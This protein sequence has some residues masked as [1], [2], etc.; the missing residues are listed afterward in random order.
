MRSQM[1]VS[2][3]PTLPLSGRQEAIAV[4]ADSKAACPLQGLVRRCRISTGSDCGPTP[5]KQGSSHLR[6]TS[7]TGAQL[8]SKGRDDLQDGV[9]AR[10]P[11]SRLGLVETFPGK[12]R[13]SGHLGHPL[14]PRDVAQG[15]GDEDGISIRLLDAGFQVGRHVL[16]CA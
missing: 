4:K 15:L 12:S 6:F 14:G 13:L 10:A 1:L 7:H 9:K 3:H 11:L 16:G 2:I 8:Q 5:R